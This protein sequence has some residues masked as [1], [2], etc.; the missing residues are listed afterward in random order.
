MLNRAAVVPSQ[1]SV[2]VSFFYITCLFCLQRHVTTTVET[3][4]TLGI[5][6]C[7]AVCFTVPFVCCCRVC[8][9]FVKAQSNVVRWYISLSSFCPL[10]FK[11][12]VFLILVCVRT[13]KHSDLKSVFTNWNRLF[14]S[15]E[16][17]FSQCLGNVFK[18]TNF[19]GTVAEC[20][21]KTIFYLFLCQ[22]WI[23]SRKG[24]RKYECSHCNVVLCFCY[25]FCFC[26]FAFWL[27]FYSI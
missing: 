25:L 20:R 5:T 10:T 15:T 2:T 23:I 18:F 26:L 24:L 27:Q 21:H 11:T 1:N 9:S 6:L 16:S 4:L 14:N 19:A 22:T 8:S 13:F 7:A 12:L 17:Q 3:S